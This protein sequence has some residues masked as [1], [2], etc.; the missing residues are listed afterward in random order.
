MPES[1]LQYLVDDC[2]VKSAPPARAGVVSRDERQSGHRERLLA[3][4]CCTGE[5]ESRS[6][7]HLHKSRNTSGKPS[8]LPWRR[9]LLGQLPRHP[10]TCGRCLERG[11]I[12]D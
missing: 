1:S 5:P 11:R 10:V 7:L 9:V 4:G 8:L 12:R 3:E 6:L 2:T